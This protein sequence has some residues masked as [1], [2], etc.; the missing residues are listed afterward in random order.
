ME[1]KTSCS[2]FEVS[3][4]RTGEKLEK[5][6]AEITRKGIEKTR[7]KWESGS[8]KESRKGKNGN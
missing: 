3:K 7:R 6:A 8:R 1:R 4:K 5:R 2:T